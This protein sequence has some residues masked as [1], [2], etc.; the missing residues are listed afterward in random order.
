V[1]G[2]NKFAGELGRHKDNLAVKITRR[3]EIEEPL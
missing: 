3:A 1:Q 2:R